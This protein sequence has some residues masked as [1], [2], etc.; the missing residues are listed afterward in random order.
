MRVA[1]FHG[2]DRPL[3]LRTIEPPQPGAGEAVV[4]V[5]CCTLCGSDLHTLNGRRPAPTPLVL[6]HEIAGEVLSIGEG[7]VH[8][9]DGNPLRPGDRV[10]WSLVV[11]CGTCSSCA[12]GRPYHCTDRFK[13]GHEPFAT[14]PF[15]G[16]L[17]EQCRLAR[18]TAIARLPDALPDAVAA[19]ASCAA[20]TVAAALRAAGAIRDRSVAVFGAGLLGLTATAMAKSLGAMRVSLL[21]IDADRAAR[22]AAFGAD[23]TTLDGPAD[24]C[25][26]LSGATPAVEQA[27]ASLAVGGRLVLVGSVAP[28]PDASLSPE[29]IVRR[30]ARIEGV[31]NY[32]PQD[33]ASAVAFLA[34]DPQP[35][36]DLIDPPVDLDHV[37][38]A[39]ATS[40]FRTAV[41]P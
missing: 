22:G 14:A 40:G 10:T 29:Q 17:G 1:L 30:R 4:R 9:L 34:T 3:E 15:S 16:G 33:L 31:H 20:A 32:E 27:F 8:D 13:Y 6:G 36:A 21:D 35:F 28:A 11:P 12:A 5:R 26:E 38:E 2:P 18:G 37:H 41:V 7:G 25:L 23:A 39:L 19:T 24:V